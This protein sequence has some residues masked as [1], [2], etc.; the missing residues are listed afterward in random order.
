MVTNRRLSELFALS[1]AELIL[2]IEELWD[3][4]ASAPESLPLTDAQRREL[5]W[6]LAA[7]EL[8]P[9]AGADWEAVKRHI[10]KRS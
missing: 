6:R 5:D 1:A 4:I 2:L 8:D 3:S 10:T 7:R 9:L